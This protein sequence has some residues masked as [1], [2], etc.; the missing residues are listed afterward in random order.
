STQILDQYF[1]KSAN[2]H[3]NKQ[4]SRRL[5]TTLPPP[6][7]EQSP[8][9]SLSFGMPLLFVA[10]S[11]FCDANSNEAMQASIVPHLGYSNERAAQFEKR[12][13]RGFSD[14]RRPEM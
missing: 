1:H 7:S 12:R 6:K 2:P 5:K 8:F 13:C 11:P 3:V 14:E 9:H 10:L 4:N